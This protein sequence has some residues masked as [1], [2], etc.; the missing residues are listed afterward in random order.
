MGSTEPQRG[1]AAPT[2]L[3]DANIL[4]A[5]FRP[6]RAFKLLLDGSRTGQLQLIVPEIA[7]REAANKFEEKCL[8]ERRALDKALAGLA[9]IGARVAEQEAVDPS[10]EALRYEQ[11]MRK[12]LKAAKARIPGLPAIAHAELLEWALE[13]RKPFKE[14]G[15][16]YR[17]ALLWA[18]VLEESATKEVLFFTRDTSDFATEGRLTDDLAQ[19]VVRMCGSRTAVELKTDL[20]AFVD[21]FV[22]V[23]T[24]AV[25]GVRRVL[26]Y[27]QRDLDPFVRRVLFDADLDREGLS[28]IAGNPA[29]LAPDGMVGERVAVG[30]AQV[31]EVY[32]VFAADVEK[33]E[34]ISTGDVLADLYVEAEVDLD[35]EMDIIGHDARTGRPRTASCF[36]A[37]EATL[38]VDLDATFIDDDLALSDLT[39]YGVSVLRGGRSTRR[40]P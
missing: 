7:L 23:D 19:D 26:S 30:D 22:D 28:R 34:V 15:A 14:N 6:G 24:V 18:N 9:R 1:D 29:D 5:N 36:A 33:A 35:V 27:I 32:D 38:G 21:E 12:A 40:R 39:F 37:V 3:L 4:I 16:G 20:A 10:A 13:R 25:E 17:D 31:L 8:A 2:I 11:E